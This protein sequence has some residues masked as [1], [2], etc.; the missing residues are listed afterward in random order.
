[1]EQVRLAED[2]DLPA[3]ELV[4]TE[5][6]TSP[7]KHC[8]L[9]QE[10]VAKGAEL[11]A[12]A[13]AK[14]YGKRFHVDVGRLIGDITTVELLT[15][16]NC[17]L[18]F[19]FPQIAGDSSFYSSLLPWFLSRHSLEER[20]QSN[21]PL[22]HIRPGT[23]VLEVGCGL[24][25]LRTLLPADTSYVGLELNAAAVAAARERQVDVR[26]ELVEQHARTAAGRYDVVCSFQVLEHVVDVRSFVAGCVACLRPGGTLI[27]SVPDARS[28]VGHQVDNV[29]NMPPHHVS[30]WSEAPLR[31]LAD[32][33]GLDVVAIA[34]DD[35]LPLHTRD[36][37]RTMAMNHLRRIFGIRSDFELDGWFYTLRR[38]AAALAARMIAP[39][40][41]GMESAIRGHSVTAVLRKP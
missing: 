18:R 13:L 31:Y 4:A 34:E 21:L 3:T 24:G 15:C 26:D 11:D 2:S 36:F 9:C 29:L 30:W 12:H 1:M 19:F 6:G 14:A 10:P 40:L 17:G 28:F 33:W 27:L 22:T 8:P 37:A 20:N 41:T 7:A 38:H 39:A 25:T 5:T 23:K 35:L 16:R 32:T